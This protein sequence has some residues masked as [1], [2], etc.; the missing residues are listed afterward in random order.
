[1]L[2][3]RSVPGK[4]LLGSTALQNQGGFGEHITVRLGLWI[5]HHWPALRQGTP[6]TG[7]G[8][9]HTVNGAPCG[10]ANSGLKERNRRGRTPFLLFPDHPY[11]RL[12]P[13]WKNSKLIRSREAGIVKGVELILILNVL[14]DATS[15]QR[16]QTISIFESVI[17]C[18]VKGLGDAVLVT[19]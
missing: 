14:G 11:E 3:P 9:H 10:C 18:C 12:E 15:L 19:V 5:R 4:H 2:L 8:I 13:G 16:Q 1:M 17:L 6:C 7:C